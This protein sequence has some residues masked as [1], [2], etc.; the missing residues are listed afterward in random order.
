MFAFSST[1]LNT[2][3]QTP[4]IYYIVTQSSGIFQICWNSY[5][6][7]YNIQVRCECALRTLYHF[8]LAIPAKRKSRRCSK[9]YVHTLRIRLCVCVVQNK[10]RNQSKLNEF[11]ENS[12]S[13]SRFGT[14]THSHI[15]M[16]YI[17]Q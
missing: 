1:K 14:R 3:C 10:E 7:V 2:K 8:T 6:T 5:S 16:H 9:M 12:L 15:F 17:Q 11:S 4:K 13:L